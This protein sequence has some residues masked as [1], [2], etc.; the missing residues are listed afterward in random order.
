MVGYWKPFLIMADRAISEPRQPT[1]PNF[2]GQKK[3]TSE[4]YNM[5]TKF[6]NISLLL[7]NFFFLC[8]SKTPINLVEWL[9]SSIL[10]Q[11]L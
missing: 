3:T 4:V 5:S 10:N 6:N 2:R 9:V 7:Y 1:A 8:F 11:M